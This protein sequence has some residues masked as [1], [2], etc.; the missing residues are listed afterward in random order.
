MKQLIIF[1]LLNTQIQVKLF[2]HETTYHIFIS[3]HIDTRE[4]IQSR[5]N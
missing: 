5:N 3:K 1:S 4:I 2:N